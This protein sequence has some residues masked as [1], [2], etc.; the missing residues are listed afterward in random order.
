MKKEFDDKNGLI[1]NIQKFSIHDGQGIRTLIFMKGCPLRCL[2]CCNPES[3]RFSEDLLYIRTKC[4][5]CGLCL[6][7]CPQKAVRPEDFGIQ[8]EKCTV[9]GS[10]TQVCYANAKKIAGRWVTRH[11]LLAEI[12]KDRIVYR[13]SGGGVTIG[14]GEPTS[15]PR[16]VKALLKDCQGLNLHTAIETCGY[17]DWGQI[18]GIFDHVD[19]IFWDLKCMDPEKHK[20]LTGVTNAVILENARKAAALGRETTFRIPLIPGCNDDEENVKSTARFVADLGDHVKLEILSYHRLGEDK[21]C[22][23]YTS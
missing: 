9:C 12:E 16:F 20:A 17:G 5:G 8:R 6:R 14:G 22:L 13:N 19:Q 18:G 1:F 11:E 15:Q 23:L 7:A 21:F 3:Q 4:I 2:W 10:C